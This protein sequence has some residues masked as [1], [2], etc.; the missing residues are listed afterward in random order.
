M[1]STLVS[2]NFP[3][4]MEFDLLSSPNNPRW[5]WAVVLYVRYG[6]GVVVFSVALVLVGILAANRTFWHVGT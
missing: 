6:M 2:V 5:V 3:P 4:E 1:P